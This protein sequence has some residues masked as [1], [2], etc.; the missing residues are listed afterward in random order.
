[1]LKVFERSPRNVDIIGF[2]IHQNRTVSLYAVFARYLFA[3][4]TTL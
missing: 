3:N 4:I 2:L 1:M